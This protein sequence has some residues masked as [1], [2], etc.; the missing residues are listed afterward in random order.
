[1]L[2]TFPFGVYL[3]YYFKK[4]WKQT[5]V[6]TFCLSLF[7][8]L[9]QL[10]GLYFIYPRSYRLFDVN[11]LL[12]NTLGGVF[13]YL[14]TPIFTFL[15][16]TRAEN[17]DDSYE[18][19]TDVTYVRRGVAWAIDWL[20]IG[21]FNTLLAVFVRLVTKDETISLDNNLAVYYVQVLLYFIG[22][23]YL[24]N[25]QTLGKKMVRI[26]VVE[27]DGKRLS[28]GALIK[29][30]GLFYLFYFT[31][32]RISFLLATGIQSEDYF[33]LVISVILSLLIFVVQATFVINIIWAII[34]KNR[35]LFYEKISRT[36]TISTIEK[37]SA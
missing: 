30:Y 36:H 22:L 28:L 18:K 21:F 5:V 25:G 9:T 4:S 13:G 27:D 3:R 11:D 23:P 37:R 20:V 19:G 16:P 15:L 35:R 14:M 6:L 26:R 24:T 33:Q 10:T 29:R 32:T 31:L 2:L 8:E 34:R 1:M 17:D 12:H 7:F